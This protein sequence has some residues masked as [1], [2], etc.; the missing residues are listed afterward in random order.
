[1]EEGLWRKGSTQFGKT[2]SPGMGVSEDRSCSVFWQC[3][4]GSEAV[5]LKAVEIATLQGWTW[6][7]LARGGNCVQTVCSPLP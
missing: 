4:E 6:A 5:P 2:M 3:S 7:R 1:M